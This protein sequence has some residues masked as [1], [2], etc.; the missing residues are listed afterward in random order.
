MQTCYFQFD[1]ATIANVIS[2]LT[3]LILVFY[4][5]YSRHEKLVNNYFQGFV[6]LFSG[7]Q[8]K[9][10]DQFGWYV[11]MGIVLS[12]K[13]ASKQ[14]VLGE[15]EYLEKWTKNGEEKFKSAGIIGIYGKMETGLL[16]ESTYTSPVGD[17]NLII[18]GELVFC[19][20]FNLDI[21][22]FN[23]W[24]NIIGKY[25]INHYVNPNIL[26]FQL[27]EKGPCWNESIHTKKMVV[28]QKSN[29]F[30]DKT[31]FIVS[32]FLNGK[33]RLYNEHFKQNL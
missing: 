30:L 6:G 27:I 2:V 33:S 21:S 20:P 9:G 19:R 3:A 25:K 28:I 31:E 26:E 23:D 5:F 7:I 13:K 15:L 8:H 18:R 11:N 17:S 24:E 10:T 22:N 1:L 32:E 14:L 29:F 16:L 12:I 4:F